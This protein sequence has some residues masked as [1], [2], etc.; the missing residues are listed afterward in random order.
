[1]G[2]TVFAPMYMV[3]KARGV[4]IGLLTNNVKEFGDSWRAMFPIDELCEVV[5]DSSDVGMRK[6]EREIYELIC[7]RMGIRPDDAIFVDDNPD[8]VAAARKLGMHAVH[9]KEDP[10]AA[11]E[12]LDTLLDQ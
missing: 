10:W 11:L 1:M 3:L 8:N 6:P 2:D 5:V 12:A 4:R 7:D 9:F